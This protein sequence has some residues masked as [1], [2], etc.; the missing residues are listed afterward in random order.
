MTR[1]PSVLSI[2]D[3]PLAELSAARLDGELTG[4][5]GS[6]WPIDEVTSPAQRARALH[7]GYSDRLIVEQLSAAWVWGALDTP[8]TPTQFCVSLDARARPPR[9]PWFRVREVVIEP[10]DCAIIGGVSITTPLRTTID[11]LRFAKPFGPSEKR[12]IRWLLE[13][14]EISPADC[15]DSLRSRTNLPRRAEAIRRLCEL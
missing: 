13:V 15:L 10:S 12:A 11:L 4:I 7:S 3:L 14:H 9:K 6:Y 1:L 5:V 2:D 8:P